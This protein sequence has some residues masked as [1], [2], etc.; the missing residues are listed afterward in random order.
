MAYDFNSLINKYKHIDGM[1]STINPVRIELKDNANLTKLRQK[2]YKCND[3]AALEWKL[4]TMSNSNIIRKGISEICSPMYLIPKSKGNWRPVCDYRLLNAMTKHVGFPMPLLMD[5]LQ[6]FLGNHYFSKFDQKNGFFNLAV[7]EITSICTTLGQFLMLRL[8]QGLKQS[9]GIFAYEIGNAF[10]EI[11]N[12]AVFVDDIVLMDADLPNHY[13]SVKKFIDIA[14]EK[15]ININWEK[16]TLAQTSV[17]FCGFDI[18]SE[19]YK[20]RSGYLIQLKDVKSPTTRRECQKILGMLSWVRGFVINFED[21]IAPVRLAGARKPFYWD[22]QAEYAFKWV[23]ELLENTKLSYFDQGPYDLY[24]DASGLAIGC[25]LYQNGRLIGLFSKALDKSERNYTIHEKEMYAIEKGI[26]KYGKYVGSNL[27]RIHC[28]SESAGWFVRGY[29][30]KLTNKVKNWIDIV[31]PYNIQYVAIDGKANGQ[32]DLLSRLPVEINHYQ[33]RSKARKLNEDRLD[34]IPIDDDEDERSRKIPAPMDNI[35]T[36]QPDVTACICNENIER[37]IMV[38]CS[39]CD[40]LSHQDC[41]G[42][43]END[44]NND[45]ICHFCRGFTAHQELPT[46]DF[47]QGAR[48]SQS[49]VHSLLSLAHKYHAAIGP[50]RL[51][52]SNYHFKSKDKLI[53]KFVNDCE[54]CKEKRRPKMVQ[55]KFRMPQGVNDI[56]GI[57]LMEIDEDEFRYICV[58]RDMFSGCVLL[59]P[60]MN[61]TAKETCIGLIKY[62]S[63]WGFPSLIVSD[64]GSEYLG[65]FAAFIEKEYIRLEKSHPDVKKEN[66]VAERA[67]QTVQGVMRVIRKEYPNEDFQFHVALCELYINNTPR[68][69]TTFS[70]IELMTLQATNITNEK[71]YLSD[72]IRSHVQVQLSKIKDKQMTK[73]NRGLRNDEEYQVGDPVWFYP[74]T[75]RKKLQQLAYLATIVRVIRD[76]QYDLVVDGEEEKTFRAHADQLLPFTNDLATGDCDIENV[77][78]IANHLHHL[79]A[80][81]QFS[82]VGNTCWNTKKFDK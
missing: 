23:I 31:Q 54:Y 76:K 28:D 19:G 16:S 11:P 45:F 37:D 48:A 75:N 49:E 78:V 68:T 47:Q 77:E 1:P 56:V 80:R 24:T 9:M 65:E 82:L 51:L 52:L 41:Y 12:K 57:D 66:R 14:T 42:L 64:E 38:F 33:T 55:M 26:E 7:S 62:C 20:C 25:T 22:D 18:D 6:R 32:A 63:K 44:L 50:M 73:R 4:Q 5:Q 3:V 30:S 35:E 61:K 71:E 17:T 59:H 67:I 10:V 74:S 27:I 40:R 58:I 2:P 81:G 79:K 69:T 15:N 21:I 53:I 70:P 13:V 43:T 39:E 60:M 8:G 29:G 46:G 34:V 36:L 72:T